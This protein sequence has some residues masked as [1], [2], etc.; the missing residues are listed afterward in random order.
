MGIKKPD[1]FVLLTQDGQDSYAV[2]KRKQPSTIKQPLKIRWVMDITFH[3]GRDEFDLDFTLQPQHIRQQCIAEDLMDEVFLMNTKALLKMALTEAQLMEDAFF[4]NLFRD[5]FAQHFEVNPVDI[6]IRV[7][8]DEL[9]QPESVFCTFDIERGKIL[10]YIEDVDYQF[11]E[12]LYARCLAT[13]EMIGL[14]AI[15]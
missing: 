4:K 11:C 5:F 2:A 9:M 7:N 13:P 3:D 14:H 10:Q 15:N 12:F 1:S 6:V 8:Y